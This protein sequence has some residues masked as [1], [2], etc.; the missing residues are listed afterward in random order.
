MLLHENKSLINYPSNFQIKII[1]IMCNNFIYAVTNIILKYDPTFHINRIRKRASSNK[2][3]LSLTVTIYAVNP[4]QLDNLY[5][6]LS[7]NSMVKFIF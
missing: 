4:Q 2:K 7:I 1:G 6:T 5:K 3:Y